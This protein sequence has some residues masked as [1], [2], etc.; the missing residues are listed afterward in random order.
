MSKFFMFF[1]IHILEDIQPTLNLKP[2]LK[3]A[4]IYSTGKLD[5]SQRE[6]IYEFWPWV[7]GSRFV[8]SMFFPQEVLYL[9]KADLVF[10]ESHT[11]HPGIVKAL[12]CMRSLFTFHD[13]L[14]KIK[15]LSEREYPGMNN[16]QLFT[17]FQRYFHTSHPLTF[18]LLSWNWKDLIPWSVSAEISGTGKELNHFCQLLKLFS[19]SSPCGFEWFS[20][21]LR[22][23]AVK[24]EKSPLTY[25]HILSLFDFSSFNFTGTNVLVIQDC[26]SH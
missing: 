3:P 20:K 17:V 26:L 5:E 19:L 1:M 14:I 24:L 15:S 22:L 2:T 11:I 18:H 7:C 23:A 12:I 8:V 9:C 16:G 25:T 4:V 6:N 13:C 10:H 21:D